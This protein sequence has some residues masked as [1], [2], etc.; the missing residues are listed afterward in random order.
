MRSK[1]LGITIILALAP[2]QATPV[3]ARSSVRPTRS[4]R[5]RGLRFSSDRV[6]WHG[7]AATR[8]SIR[9]NNRPVSPKNGGGEPSI[10]MG[11]GKYMYVSYPGDGG[12]HFFYSDNRGRTWKAGGFADT[13]SG[14][15]SVNIDSS[16]AVYQ[17]NLDGQ[18]QGDVY[19]S[20]DHGK[21]W[22][23]PGI[24][25]GAA[26]DGSST[27]NPGHVDREWTDAY[28]AP[29]KTS[30][31]ADVYIG[32]HDF[33][34]SDVWVNASHD[35]GKTF[36][37]AVNVIVEPDAIASSACNTIPGS[38]RV[39]QAGKHAGRIYMSWIASDAASSSA[40]GCNYT[41]EDTFYKA[42]V[43]WSDD[44]G[45]TWND[46]LVYD[47]AVT[48]DMGELFPDMTLDRKGNPY[49]VVADN[50]KFDATTQDKG[51][52]DVYLFASFDGGKHWNKA[53]NGKPYKVSKSTGTHYFP[54][55]AA[56]DPGMVDVAWIETNKLPAVSLYGK[57]EY[58]SGMAG[59]LWNVYMGQTRNLKTGHP[60]WKVKKVTGAPM[61]EG[62]V[63]VLG[64]FCT[65]FGPAGANRDILDFIDIAVDRKGRSHIAYTA[66][67]AD[68]ACICVAHQTAGST[69]NKTLLAP[70]ATLGF[71]TLTPKKGRTIRAKASL[72]RC[73]PKTRGTRIQLQKKVGGTFKTI[74]SHSL[75]AGCESVFRIKASFDK[76]TFRSFWKTQN[77]SYR[78][79]HSR[80]K[81]VITHP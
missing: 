45:V 78:S 17:S 37:A 12:M 31:K 21:T 11:K 71:N 64:I 1:L 77:F 69:V 7:Q 20:H 15:T 30:K 34:P 19:K 59:A 49:V 53:H 38:L 42:W 4:T 70:K 55:V 24:S 18:L 28:I 72:R 76:A 8:E 62:D 81:T 35:G 67:R 13:G 23:G 22:I 32:Y 60:S 2:L 3:V 33:G 56:G 6:A 66:D 73:N 47:G 51:E 50:L 41:Q 54:A 5:T 61:H 65:G 36:G 46:Q 16:G 39:A 48:H 68:S 40:S 80:S 14:D 74:K 75:D 52:W 63:C 25:G 10:A 58:P 26:S 9:N 43:A 79:G 27:N 57:P 44:G 29:G